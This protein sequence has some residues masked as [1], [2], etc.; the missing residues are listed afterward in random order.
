MCVCVSDNGER[1][2]VK[3]AVSAVLYL[4]TVVPCFV[5]V[6]MES[7]LDWSSMSAC[8]VLMADDD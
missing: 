7:S 5:F 4:Y 8:V 2:Q 3:E 1:K 6:Y